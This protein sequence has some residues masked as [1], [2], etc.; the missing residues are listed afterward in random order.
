MFWYDSCILL[1]VVNYFM[2][3]TDYKDGTRSLKS[4][5]ET[6]SR[7]SRKQICSLTAYQ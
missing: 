3:E 2:I 4:T 1:G 7:G 6:N 5:P